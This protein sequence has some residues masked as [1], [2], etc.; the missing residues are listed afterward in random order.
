MELRHRQ[1]IESLV[2]L[3]DDSNRPLIECAI[4]EYIILE[5][6]GNFFNRARAIAGNL[7]HKISSLAGGAKQ[8]YAT[9][10]QQ[11]PQIQQQKGDSGE[12]KHREFTPQQQ[13]AREF[14]ISND[15]NTWENDY[16]RFLQACDDITYFVQNYGNRE[17]NQLRQTPDFKKAEKRGT[18]M[19]E[20]IRVNPQKLRDEHRTAYRNLMD[21]V[22][23]VSPEH[24]ALVES[25][26][27]I[28]DVTEGVTRTRVI[29]LCESSNRDYAV[30][31]L[32]NDMA[33]VELFV[34]RHGIYPWEKYLKSAEFRDAYMNSGARN[35]EEEK[36]DEVDPR[37]I[38][39]V[40]NAYSSGYGSAME[41]VDGKMKQLNKYLGK[42]P[43]SDIKDSKGYIDT[44]HK[45]FNYFKDAHIQEGAWAVHFTNDKAYPKIKK[46]G[47]AN[48]TT[49]LDH[50]AYTT[51]YDGGR[52]K[53]GWLFALPVDC[54]Y[55]KHY[56]MGYGDCA[57]LIKADGVI[58]RHVG[59]QDDE[60]IFRDKDVIKKVPFRYDY[61]TKKWVVEPE[62]GENEAFDTI[63][64]VIEAY[65]D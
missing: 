12:L 19:D 54:E 64:Q 15:R 46:N 6:T 29:P 35:P 3:A 22:C 61:D 60:L 39:A 7:K 44:T 50:L 16:N 5:G 25:I 2:S 9:A 49:V 43:D 34:T 56:D 55:L 31:Q 1:F 27:S 57:F 62:D 20:Y 26:L 23:R 65:R 48:G 51:M 40:R 63:G 33:L 42:K 52:G 10:H 59:E 28:Y 4:K 38:D 18:L 24:R 17:F 21:S 30:S 11:P 53:Q 32:K 47:F 58:A 8:A 41:A 14:L 13:K 45:A 37:L 36:K